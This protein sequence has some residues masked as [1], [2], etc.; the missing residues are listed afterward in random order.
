VE[1]TAE[2]TIVVDGPV[3]LV[4][5]IPK[6]PIRIIV[7]NGRTVKIDGGSKAMKPRE[8][9]AN[10]ENADNFAEPSIGTNPWA[11]LTSPIQECKKA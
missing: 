3:T 7:K 1:G 2:G 10:Y 9:V 11:R 5:R 6:E 4:C 8:I